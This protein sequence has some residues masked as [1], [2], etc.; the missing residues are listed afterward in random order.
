M[1]SDDQCEKRG[2]VPG[3]KTTLKW[4]ISEKKGI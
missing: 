3:N 2:K 4:V 1:D